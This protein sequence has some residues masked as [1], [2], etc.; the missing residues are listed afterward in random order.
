MVIMK[1]IA[2]TLQKMFWMQIGNAQKT[3]G[4][5]MNG[6]IEQTALDYDLPVYIVAVLYSIYIEA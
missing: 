1:T 2:K 6:F 5:K 4:S 3:G